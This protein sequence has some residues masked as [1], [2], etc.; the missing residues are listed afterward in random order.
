MQISRKKIENGLKR[1]KF[2][3][4]N[5]DHRFFR[6]IVDGKISSIRTFTSHGSGYKDYNDLLLGMMKRELKLENI[7]QLIRLIECPLE[8]DAYIAY[9]RAKGETL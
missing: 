7:S 6:L 5:K 3:K 8:Y 9:L 2:I 1:K 4:D